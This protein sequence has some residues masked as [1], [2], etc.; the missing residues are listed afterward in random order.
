MFS[1]A[2]PRPYTTALTKISIYRYQY[3]Y[4]CYCCYCYYRYCCYGCCYS[5]YQCCYYPVTGITKATDAATSVT[6]TGIGPAI[7]TIA[8]YYYATTPA[9][10]TTTKQASH[11]HKPHYKHFFFIHK[12][13][14]LCITLQFNL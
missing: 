7:I 3:Y 11:F 8:T 12:V 6:A 2:H 13:R 1:L 9:I 10:N 4:Y 14:R 5:C